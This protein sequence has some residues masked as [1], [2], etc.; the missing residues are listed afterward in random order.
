MSDL[1]LSQHALTRMA[2]RGIRASDIA[3]M[4]TFG[5]EVNDGFLVRDKDVQAI[6]REVKAFLQRLR[7][8]QGKRLIA[9]DGTLVTAFHATERQTRR[10]LQTN[11][12]RAL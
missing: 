6:E 9:R 1:H 2:Q 4:M 7:Q 11:C 10:L 3:L 12:G 8:M 5:T